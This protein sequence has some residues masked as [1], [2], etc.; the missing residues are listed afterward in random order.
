M[1][2]TCVSLQWGEWTCC[3]V[4]F[5]AS[6]YLVSFCLAAF[7]FEICDWNSSCQ[8]SLTL[9]RS[10]DKSR[11]KKHSSCTLVVFL[12]A[13]HWVQTWNQLWK[14]QLSRHSWE[15]GQISAEWTTLNSQQKKLV[16]LHTCSLFS[17]LCM[18]ILAI[19]LSFF[20]DFTLVPV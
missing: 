5:L 20:A 11:C 19:V 17:V 9:D 2:L 1:E 15:I 7:R 18:N 4:Q 12:A 8:I 6:L 10:L 3:L 13:W 14:R 16:F